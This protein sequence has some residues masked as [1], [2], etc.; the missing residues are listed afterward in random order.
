MVKHY[1]FYIRYGR[2]V[3]LWL[4]IIVSTSDMEASYYMVK[5]TRFYI[6]YG[7]NVIPWLNVIVSTS[8]MEAKLFYG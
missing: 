7:S 3:I 1:R 5:R 4:N 8:D 6:R 2:K